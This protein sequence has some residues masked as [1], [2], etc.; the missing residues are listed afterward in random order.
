MLFDTNIMQ[1]FFSIIDYL[2]PYSLRKSAGQP[3][4]RMGPC[5]VHAAHHLFY[6]VIGRWMDSACRGEPQEDHSEH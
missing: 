2:I 4:R 6:L 1:A 5:A 3:D